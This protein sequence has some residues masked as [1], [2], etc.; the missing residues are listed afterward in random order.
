MDNPIVSIIIATYNSGKTIRCALDSVKSQSYQDWECVV[1]DGASKDDTMD[2][3]REYADNDSRFR[4]VSEPD[5]G[6]YD[7]FNKGWKMAAGEWVHY[8]GSDDRLTKDGLEQLLSTPNL[9]D[10]EIVSGNC[11]IEKIDGTIKENISKGFGG[12]HQGKLTRKTALERFGGFDERF[13][14]MADADL[15]IRME[16]AGVKILNVSAFVAYF[17][18]TGASQSIS[19]L[20]KRAKEWYGI[21]KNNHYSKPLYRA[22]R[23]YVKT[24][25]AISYRELRKSFG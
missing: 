2:I 8:L 21:Y 3:V 18:M 19:G 6:I 12:C 22:C 15:M 1:V 5:H 10:Y 11:Y 14:I 16:Q 24:F 13:S 23:Y 9:D 25:A 20:E 4:Y 7:A 17:V